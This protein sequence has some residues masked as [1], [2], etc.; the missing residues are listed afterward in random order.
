MRRFFS[1]AL[2]ILCSAAITFSMSGGIF[3]SSDW[4]HIGYMGDL[5]RDREIT[6]ADLVIMSKHLHGTQPLSNENSYHVRNSFI[7]IHGADG[8]QAGEYFVTADINQ[9]GQVDVFDMIEL[10]KAILNESALYVWEWESEQNLPEGNLENYGEFIGAPVQDVNKF[11]P[12]QGEAKLLIIYADF[13]DCKYDYYPS[14]ELI[15]KIAFGSEDTSSRMYPFESASAFYSRSS[16][17]AMHLSG[18]AYPYTAKESVKNYYKVPGQKKLLTEALAELDVKVDY[19][20]YDGNNDGYIDTVLLVVPKEAGDETWWPAAVQFSN[21]TYKYDGLQIGHMITGNCQIQ[22]ERDYRDFTST[23]LHEMGH[24]MGLPD[25]YLYDAGDDHDG[26]HGTAGS[27]MMDDSGGDF[28]CVSKL[29]LG[30]YKQNQV[31]KYE[32][33]EGYEDYYLYNAQSDMGNTLII[34]CGEMD[35]RYHCEC[36]MVEYTTKDGNNSSPPWYVPMGEGVRIY[37]ADMTLYDNGWWVSYKYASGSEFTNDYKGRR[38]IRLVNDSEKDNILQTGDSVDL[39]TEG[40]GWYDENDE[41]TI[42]PRIRITVG[43]MNG[44]YCTITVE[45]KL[46]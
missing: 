6:M 18:N 13:E 23:I 17:G 26:L 29:Q 19:H 36:I 15:E 25:Y 27:E 7:G 31:I 4:E 22:S 12:S 43:E 32:P 44:D 45:N 9:D 21:D 42:D 11:L 39:S 46:I 16:K 5:N 8:F 35:D 34:P 37:H 20:D 40:F 38:F 41:A 1:K 28:S 14:C 30:W 3:A 33:Y 2:S 10:R 24:C